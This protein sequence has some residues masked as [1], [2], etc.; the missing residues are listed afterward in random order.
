MSLLQ[1]L[2][3][4]QDGRGL[5]SLAEQV[6]LDPARANEL[7]E[8]LAPVIGQATKAQAEG[9]G[10][11][12]IVGSLQ[13]QDQAANYDRPDQ[14]ASADGQ[15]QGQSFLTGILGTEGTEKLTRQA[16]EKTGLDA[17]QVAAFLPAL[18]AM[19]QGGLQKTISDDALSAMMNTAKSGA[20]PHAGG[21][22]GRLSGLFGRAP[23]G[24]K[25]EGGALNLLTSFLDAD[26]DGSITDDILEKI[27]N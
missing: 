11:A 16:A 3:K 19:A 12:G 24:A 14:A 6:G 25:N 7:T 15:A 20:E 1:L 4:A 18:A 2:Q 9:G 8:I 5:T 22:M 10:L 27:R 13:G 17:R 23:S 21:I 26:G